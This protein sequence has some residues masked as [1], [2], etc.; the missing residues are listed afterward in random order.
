V[1]A[2]ILNIALNLWLIPTMG[3]SGAALATSISY[4][5]ATFAVLIVFSPE[6]R[7][8]AFLLLAPF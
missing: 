5:V 3:I 2:M 4:F 1:S 7:R 6:T 8:N